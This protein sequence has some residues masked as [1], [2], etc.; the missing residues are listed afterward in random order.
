MRQSWFGKKF[1]AVVGILLCLVFA[2]FGSTLV[3]TAM[4]A[5]KAA[6]KADGESQRIAFARFTK[7]NWQ[8]W[9]ISPEG[10]DARQITYS[11]QDKR[12]PVWIH[13]G[14]GLAFRTNNGQLFTLHLVTRQEKEILK[15]Y[16]NINNPHCANATDEIVFVR[17]DPRSVDIS[18][19]WKTDLDGNHPVLLSLGD[20]RL[21][22]QPAFSTDGKWIVFVKADGDNK[23]HHL[24]IMDAVGGAARQLTE[25]KGFDTLPAFSPDGKWVAFSSNREDGDY[26]IYAVNVSSRKIQRLTHQPGLDSAPVFSPDG[27]RIAFVSTR[28]GSQQIWVMNKDGSLPMQLTDGP[29]EAIDPDWSKVP[30]EKGKGE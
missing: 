29:Q 17:F 20:K 13:K 15:Q 8:V 2:E 10:K 12:N 22:Y 4:A 21:K 19:I 16:N 23:H 11:N 6:P 5:K 25:G 30:I 27:K 7:Q 14:N 18:D 3:K 24:W 28:S 26:E 1:W 9:T